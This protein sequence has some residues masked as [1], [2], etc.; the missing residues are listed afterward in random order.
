M[1][2]YMRVLGWV[3]LVAGLA[4]S[5]ACWR[6]VYGDD[7]YYQALKGL[8][9]YPNNVLYI[10]DL[11]MAEPRHMLLLAGAYGLGTAGVVFGSVCLSLGSLLARSRT[12]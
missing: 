1:A 7:A 2:L 11:K 4:A 10:T 5:I 9:K 8:S 3:V 12:R 6:G